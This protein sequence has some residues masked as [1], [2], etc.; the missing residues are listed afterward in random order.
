M[1]SSLQQRKQ[2]RRDRIDE[3][4]DERRIYCAECEGYTTTHTSCECGTTMQEIE[5]NAINDAELNEAAANAEIGTYNPGAEYY[6]SSYL[7]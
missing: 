1:T 3:L 4:K 2:D 7:Q 5:E 6:A